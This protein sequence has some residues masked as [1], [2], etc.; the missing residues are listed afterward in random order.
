VTCEHAGNEVPDGFAG[1]FADAREALDSHRGWD[2]GAAGYGLRLAT[3]LNAPYLQTRV[4]RLLVEVNRSEQHPDLFSRYASSLDETTRTALLDA[5][6]RPHRDAVRSLIGGMIGGG[7]RV[8]HLSAHSFTDVLDGRVR[9]VDVGVLFDPDRRSER[10]VCEAWL[11]ELTAAAPGLRV[12]ANEPYLGTD[13]GL[14]TTLRGEF[15]TD[16]YAGVETEVRQG[17]L[18]SAPQQ[19]LAAELLCRSLRAALETR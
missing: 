7:E 15:P 6:Y 1:L 4:T 12:R 5:Y 18:R 13:D 11:A 2:I 14:T 19:R 9:E 3:L 8:L 16:S 10:A 17:M